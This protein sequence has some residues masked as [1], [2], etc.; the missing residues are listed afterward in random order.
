MKIITSL[1]V[2]SLVILGGCSNN[3]TT[4]EDTQITFNTKEKLGEALFFDANL[5][6]TRN[7]SC[8]TCHNPEHGFVDARFS[9][10]GV[11][12]SVFIH[13]AFSVGDDGVS[14]GGRNAPTAAYAMFSP[15]FA[16]GTD[17]NYSGGQ[18]H[19]G[20]A[21]T[22]KVQ[23]GGPPLDG[24]EMQMP[25]KNAVVD[26]VKENEA[27]VEAFE[28]YYGSDI[29]DDVNAS[30]EAM[31]ESIATFEKTDEFAP[32]DSKYDRFRECRASGESTT[33][34]LSADNWTI[35]EQAGY[36]LF[37]SNNN[38]SCAK[39]HTLNSSDEAHTEHEMFTNYKYENIGVPRNIAAMDARAALGFQDANATFR[40][41]GGTV[42]SSDTNFALHLGKTKVPTLRNIAVTAPYMNNGV[43]KK[44]RTVLE[45]YDH[46]GS[47]NRPNNPETDAPWGAND[48]PATINHHL[49][50]Q[51]AMDDAKIRKLEAF[52]NT[53]TDKRYEHLIPELAPVGALGN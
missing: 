1:A 44:L 21:A 35:D 18:F 51:A 22:L 34:C 43:F 14:L 52:L 5:S 29:F 10:D 32:F 15:T 41:L 49:L 3:D 37:F 4:P 8:A 45:F 24:A 19:D 25:D 40:G 27:Y 9:E 16:K 26:R 20:R 50:S 47:G 23:A 7:T 6:L 17:G 39:C 36:A 42:A 12:Q 2:A 13:G 46:M 28:T 53:L 30:Y 48:H 31:A 38:T 11:D 33:S